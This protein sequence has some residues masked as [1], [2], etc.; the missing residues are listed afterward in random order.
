M[1][2][3]RQRRQI[4]TFLSQSITKNYYLCYKDEK[5]NISDDLL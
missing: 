5:E 4:M 2:V 3:Q 1:E